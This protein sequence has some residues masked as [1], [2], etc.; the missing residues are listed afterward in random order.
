MGSVRQH[1]DSRSVQLRNGQSV[2]FEVI[3]SLQTT[4]GTLVG[5]DAEL[6]SREID[7]VSLRDGSVADLVRDSSGNLTFLVFHNGELSLHRTLQDKTATLSPPRISRSILDAVCLPNSLEVGCTAKGLLG[8]L[9]AVLEN[10]V[11]FD[12]DDRKLIARFALSS[13]FSDLSHVAPYLWIV[14]PYSCGK[15]TLARLLSVLCRRSILAANISLAGLYM[16][17]TDLHPTIIIDEFGYAADSR[18]EELLGVLR[19]GTTAG[20]RV[21]RASGAYDIF[22]PKIIASRQAPTDAALKSRG[23]VVVARPASRDLSE[24]TRTALLEIAQ[25]FQPK[26]LGFR[27]ENYFRVMNHSSPKLAFPLTPRVKDIF[28]ALVLPFRGDVDLE[29]ELLEIVAPHNREAILERHSE[30]EWYVM[31]ALL[32]RVH[33]RGAG[34]DTLT[35]KQLTMEVDYMLEQA[36]EPYRIKPRKVGE[37]LRSLGLQTEKLGSCGRGLRVSKSLMLA[38]HRKA[39]RLGICVAD[40]Y[41]PDVVTMGTPTFCKL[42][43]DEGL[44]FDNQG[45]PL[46]Y[47]EVEEFEPVPQSVNPFEK[48]ESRY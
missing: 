26:L 29:K 42:C 43:H 7:F 22:G 41:T 46:P 24:L 8:D 47:V 18:S 27:L 39:K 13:W 9:E 34:A 21:F 15:T 4:S 17:S 5:D 10:F 16:L 48:K 2:P 31:T 6:S 40:M 44:S 3:T 25:T 35:M 20:Q 33:T 38:A 19:N 30:P 28:H 36:G 11:D 23:L 1:R 37:I 45:R 32:R 12:P 14:G